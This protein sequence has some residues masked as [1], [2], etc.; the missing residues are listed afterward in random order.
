M[1]G[2]QVGK[3]KKKP[4]KKKAHQKRA[5][6]EQKGK[7]RGISIPADS[8]SGKMLADIQGVIRNKRDSLQ[9]NVI[10]LRL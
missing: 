3:P 7:C 2:K 6:P 5:S 1:T 8:I 9:R 10:K 4:D